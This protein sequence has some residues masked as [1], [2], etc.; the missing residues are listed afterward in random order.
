MPI[1]SLPEVFFQTLHTAGS[2][3]PVFFLGCLLFLMM[4]GVCK[5]FL[6]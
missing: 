3:R 6:S 5:G 1:F 2:V 4:P